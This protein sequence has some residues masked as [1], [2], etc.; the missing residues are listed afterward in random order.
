VYNTTDDV[1]DVYPCEFGFYYLVVSSAIWLSL[2]PLWICGLF[3]N[4]WR[5]WYELFLVET[6]KYAGSC[7]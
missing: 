6:K 7:G 3:G 5:Q 4:C 2:L 1:E